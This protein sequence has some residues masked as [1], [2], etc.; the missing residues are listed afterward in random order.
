MKNVYLACPLTQTAVSWDVLDIIEIPS[1]VFKLLPLASESRD[2]VE[3]PFTIPKWKKK[4]QLL[5]KFEI[6]LASTC[7]DQIR[8]KKLTLENFSKNGS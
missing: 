6:I 8:E 3:F 1:P 4:K 7:H 2:K 5:E